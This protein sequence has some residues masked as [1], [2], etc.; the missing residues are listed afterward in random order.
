M[1]HKNSSKVEHASKRH[2]DRHLDSRLVGLHPLIAY[3]E[4]T[5]GKEMAISMV[6]EFLTA[7]LK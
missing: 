5:A 3:A 7:R 6:H 2:L 1:D 4:R